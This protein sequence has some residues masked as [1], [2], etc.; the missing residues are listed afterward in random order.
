[1]GANQTERSLT[2]GAALARQEQEYINGLLSKNK[3]ILILDLDNT[4]LHAN[5]MSDLEL[6]QLL[7]IRAYFIIQKIEQDNEGKIRQDFVLIK[8]RPYFKE[9][10]YIINKLFE[11]YIY[12]KGTRIYADQICKWVRAQW[13]G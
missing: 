12:T 4:I 5:E 3:L 10:L 8:F 9:F 6:G 1:M 7:R 13:G 11:V 2:K